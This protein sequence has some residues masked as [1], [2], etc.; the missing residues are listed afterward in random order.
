MSA[1]VVAAKEQLRA[2]MKQRLAGLSHDAV[3]AQSRRIFEA[4]QDFPPYRDAARISVF[5]SM[6]AAEVQTDAIVRHALACGK[7]VFV[8]Y[9]HKPGPEAPPGAP[10][11]LMDMVSLAGLRDYESLRPDR[12]GIPSVDPASVRHRRRLLGEPPAARHP[13]DE[14]PL[15]LMLLPGVAFDLDD[16]GFVRRLGHGRGFYDYFLNRYLAALGD[17]AAPLPLYGLALTEQLLSP[18]SG[19][20]VP[21]HLHDRTLHGLVLGTGEIRRPASNAT[22]V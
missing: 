17:G 8:P 16:A 14:A 21:V 12:W 13:S 3:A 10:P 19:Q 9:L 1:P 6:P 2:L 5:L 4:L 15:D 18:S 20:S 11:R 22:A 7:Q